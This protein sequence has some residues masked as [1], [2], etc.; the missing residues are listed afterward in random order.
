MVVVVVKVVTTES[1]CFDEDVDNEATA[2]ATIAATKSDNS[3]ANETRC[4]RRSNNTKTATAVAMVIA[5]TAAAVAATTT[6]TTTASAA[7]TTT[8]TITIT[9]TMMTATAT[10]VRGERALGGATDHCERAGASD[11]DKG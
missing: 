6:A 4:G 7:A 5:V 9:I 8:I 1:S 2:A 10:A 11:S 3:F